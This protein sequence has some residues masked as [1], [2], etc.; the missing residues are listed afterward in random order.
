[1][2]YYLLL[3]AVLK[4]SSTAYGMHVKSSSLIVHQYLGLTNILS[5]TFTY[6]HTHTYSSVTHFITGFESQKCQYDSYARKFA[7][8]NVQHSMCKF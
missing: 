1:M 4:S 5:H 2:F 3:L 8:T 6:F 7:I